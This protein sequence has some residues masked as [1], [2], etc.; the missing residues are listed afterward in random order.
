MQVTKAAV[1]AALFMASSRA[2]ITEG[3]G[4]EACLA[5]AN[6]KYCLNRAT[7]TDSCCW[8]TTAAAT[9]PAACYTSWAAA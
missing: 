6:A 5:E 7:L 2:A 1:L 3:L 8:D 4:V 9:T